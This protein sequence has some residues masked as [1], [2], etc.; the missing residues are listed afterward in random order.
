M[1]PSTTEGWVRE[2]D[3]VQLICQGDGNP[4]PEYMFYRLQVTDPVAPLNPDLCDILTHT[5]F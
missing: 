1:S 5:D 2:G 4:T 3:S